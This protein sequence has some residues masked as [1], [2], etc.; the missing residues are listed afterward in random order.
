MWNDM[1]EN[2]MMS[3]L[4][5]LSAF[6]V[7]FLIQVFA[8]K[9]K[10][11]AIKKTLIIVSFLLVFLLMGFRYRVGTDY[12]NYVRLFGEYAKV[13]FSESWSWGGDIG[14][15]LIFGAA[16][17]LFSDARIVFWVYSFLTLY[18]LYKANKRYDFK[19]LAYAMLIFNFLY[20]PFCMNV[21]RQGAAM[22]FM[23]LAFC[24]MRSGKKAGAVVCA[25]ISVIL[26]TSAILM[27]PFLLA[28]WFATKS[29]RRFGRYA[30]LLTLLIAFALL[31]FMKDVFVKLNFLDYNSYFQMVGVGDTTGVRLLYQFV[32]Y[33]PLLLVLLVFARD[34][35][36]K[37]EWGEIKDWFS[38]VLCGSIM[39]IV[40]SFTQFL[41]R[42]SYYFS[43]FQIFLVPMMLQN[44]SNKNTRVVLKMAFVVF[45]VV[46]FVLRCYVW[47][48]YGIFP[49]DT[50]L[51][52]GG[53]YG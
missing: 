3:V 20:L 16:S 22:S 19:Y 34:K 7:V 11:E 24:D 45:I 30:L 1:M 36:K 37:A 6:F 39:D 21:M 12:M 53:C 32:N 10:R 31:T 27:M 46:L 15:K 8:M 28:Y 50:W 52:D 41:A 18:P 14:T 13:P 47:G 25:L 43:V 40:G 42:T 29:K 5:Y 17:H 9:Q 33:L 38:L 51:I 44:I 4:F 23:L 48:S 49:Y 26:H 35:K 2:G